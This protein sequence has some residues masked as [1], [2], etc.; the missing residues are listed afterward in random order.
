VYN[1]HIRNKLRKFK[2]ADMYG[3]I[4]FSAS[5]DAAFDATKLVTALNKFRWDSEQQRFLG[6]DKTVWFEGGAQYPTLFPKLVSSY[7]VCNEAGDDVEIAPADMTE[8]DYDNINDVNAEEAELSDISSILGECV[9]AGWIE[10][11][12]TGNCKTRYSV[13]QTMRIDASKNVK[14]TYRY[15][16]P[17]EVETTESRYDAATGVE[18]AVE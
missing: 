16:S 13:F 5:K 3:N 2:M 11:C 14:R 6:D 10:L 17:T 15:S 4:T 9:T 7:N 12:V 18:S 8:D 1:E